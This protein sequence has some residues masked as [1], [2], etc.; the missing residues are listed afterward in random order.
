MT[1]LCEESV[2][3]AQRNL[4]YDGAKDVFVLSGHSGTNSSRIAW[5]I[6]PFG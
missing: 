2:R 5:I 3:A 1:L 6:A 4:D